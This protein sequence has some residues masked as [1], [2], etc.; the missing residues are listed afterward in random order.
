MKICL[1]AGHSFGLNGEGKDPG[2][3]NTELN[4]KESYIAMEL[5]FMLGKLLAKDD[6]DVIYTRING[7]DSI[8]LKKRCETANKADADIFISIHLN[9]CDNPKAT[10]IETLRYNKSSQK[11]IALANSVQRKLIE[12]TGAKDRGVKERNDL[13]VLKRT[14]MPAILIEVGFISN[15]EEARKLS[16]DE[17]YRNS[18]V[19]AIADGIE[20]YNKL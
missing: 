14:N 12:Y 15:N 13:Y 19:L 8:T 17:E 4:L 11:S 2:A 18:I 20:A 3:I 5:V 16:E 1:D 10:G 7:S 9:S 6:H